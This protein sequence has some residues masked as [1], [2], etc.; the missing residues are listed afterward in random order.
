[1]APE[2]LLWYKARDMRPHD[3]LDFVALIGLLT[4]RER[5]WLRQAISVAD[6]AHQWLARLAARP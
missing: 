2:V 5:A 3:E 1:M 4:A 6:P